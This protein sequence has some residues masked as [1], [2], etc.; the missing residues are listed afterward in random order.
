MKC[1][2]G[3]IYRLN[4]HDNDN[5]NNYYHYYSI[6]TN[7]IYHSEVSKVNIVAYLLKARR[8][9]EAEIARQQFRNTVTISEPLLR[10][11]RSQQWRNCWKWCF[12][13]NAPSIEIV[14]RDN[15]S[16]DK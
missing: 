11:V 15:L 2:K 4:N 8:A 12:L 6:N 1:K 13:S 16:R 7:H 10:N 3:N 5:T 14:P 9:R